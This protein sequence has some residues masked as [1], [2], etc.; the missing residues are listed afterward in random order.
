MDTSKIKEIWPTMLTPFTID[1]EVDYEV[2]GHL[3]EWY[4]QR[5]VSGLFAV[6]QSSEMFHLS[7]EERV[8]IA[9][10]VKEKAASR[11]PVIASGHV[12]DQLEEQAEELCQMAGTGIDAL[13]LITNR[14][15][16]ENQSEEIVK[17]NLEKLLLKLPQHIKLGFYECPYPYKRLLSAQLLQWA[18]R[19]GRFFFL[20]DTSCDTNDIKHKLAA[21]QGT[22][23]KIFNAN[24]ATLLETL[25]LGV[26]GYSGI[27]AN[28]HPELYVW[29][30]QN[31]ERQTVKAKQL[32]S[33][34]SMTSLIEKQ[35]YP[36]NAKY[37]L[38][39]EGVMKN[40]HCRVKNNND[41]TATNAL[42]IEQLRQ[43]S[44]QLA[45]QYAIEE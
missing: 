12:A 11:V 9:S 22:Q 27:M 44:K 32:I 4:I 2:L 39:L 28:F 14:L 15:A 5:G 18:A 43:L 21:V 38:T 25:R 24:S 13:I 6:C 42:E 37:Y 16:A 33:I 31:W 34:L 35:L 10:F 23:L 45:A 19:T 17:S 20:K 8:K 41:F 29:L 3:V 1:N 40:N 7:R 30:N 36:V 26:S